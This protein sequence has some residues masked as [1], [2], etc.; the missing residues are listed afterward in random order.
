ME[1]LEEFEQYLR[2]AL[3]HLYDPTYRPPAVMW[4]VTGCDPQQ[5]VEPV[6]T[7]LIRAIEDL[8]P[9]FDV[10][11]TARIRRIH[12][13]LSYRYVQDLTQEEA[14][15]RLGITPRHLRR[16]QREAVH[17]LARRL[18]EQ[19]GFG[20]RCVESPLTDEL[21]QDN[22]MQP[23]GATPSGTKL[24]EWRSQVRQELASLQESAPGM[25][26]D[27]EGTIDSVVELESTLSARR[28]I[29]LE[30][31]YVQPNIVATIHPSVL[32][33]ILI[34]AIG[35]LVRPM[36]SGQI[37]LRAE[38]EEGHVRITVTGCPA[39]VDSPPNANLL[40]EIL[41]TQSGSVEI[42]MDGDRASFRVALPPAEEITVLVV[43]DNMD[44]VHFYRRYTAGT[45]YR[46]VH[47]AQGQHVFE[48][49][50]TSVPDIIVLDVMLPDIDGWELLVDLH[51][52]PATRTTPTIICSVI[53]EEEL[54][55]ALGAALYLPK[56]VR[57]R[58]FVQAL[59][60]VLDQVLIG[61]QQECR[62]F[63]R[64]TQ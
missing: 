64:T 53:R 38:R 47:A 7:A 28:G 41:A 60:R 58:Q 27:V 51:E 22:G 52:H 14:A 57:R 39:A 9:A 35:E 15:E 50:E 42:G 25:V 12:E 36:S 10:P 24:S 17:V 1:S 19:S 49:I 62:E 37:T 29:C 23:P 30:V 40:Q 2:D 31:E 26:A 33:Q 8:Q 48:I 46:I 45:R 3:T 21:T 5:G 32:R 44:L 59:D 6:Q 20:K 4:A 43:D 63:K 61:L 18:W 13:M 56:P 11:P 34:M 55:L 54:A 16:E